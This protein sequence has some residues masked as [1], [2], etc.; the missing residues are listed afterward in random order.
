ME[1]T[2]EEKTIKP[3][4]KDVD[5]G[6][7]NSAIEREKLVISG[8]RFGVDIFHR[9]LEMSQK[10]MGLMK[11]ATRSKVADLEI[12]KQFGPP[13]IK[14]GVPVDSK[15]LEALY[16]RGFSTVPILMNEEEVKEEISGRKAPNVVKKQLVQLAERSYLFVGKYF[17]DY[18]EYKELGIRQQMKEYKSNLNREFGDFTKD[19]MIIYEFLIGGVVKIPE[20]LSII[21][22]MEDW[23]GEVRD[24][25]AYNNHVHQMAILSTLL[26]HRCGLD[27]ETIKKIAS[28]ALF[29]DFG[30]LLYDRK[31]MGSLDIK[32]YSKEFAEKNFNDIVDLSKY[33]NGKKFVKSMDLFEKALIQYLSDKMKTKIND[34]QESNKVYSRHPL[35]SALLLTDRNGE[36]AVGI[37]IDVLKMIYQHEYYIDGSMQY[38]HNPN[39][40]D[41]ELSD[42]ISKI[43]MTLGI[44]AKTAF[45]GGNKLEKEGFDSIEK[46]VQEL[47][48]GSQILAIVERFLNL[49]AE[50]KE[51]RREPYRDTIQTMY[52][53]AG[54]KLNGK[55]WEI[56]FNT[57]VPKKYY[58]Q[59]LIVRIG[60]N[61]RNVEGMRY[62]YRDCKG[63]LIDDYDKRSGEIHKKCVIKWDSKGKLI[64]KPVVIDIGKGDFYFKIDDWDNYHRP[65]D[66]P[67]KK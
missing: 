4:L 66:K 29:H 38:S 47:E 18:S 50:L 32:K 16:K 42:E 62:N 22:V 58:P 35:Y 51:E 45:K 21:N 33:E 8:K 24:S 10:G 39:M 36:P 44:N 52:Q 43:Y 6:I 20:Q 54:K 14:R 61:K 1:A 67:K 56:F 3:T 15:T 13:L 19:W 41:R 37:D 65:G 40:Y 46:N 12:E 2:V 9:D 59:G 17:R 60:F 28:A 30:L 64:E 25:S 27:G 5:A 55:A 7:I 53:E 49:Y 23:I 31:I 48:I 11:L 26:A 63:F 34:P 57:L